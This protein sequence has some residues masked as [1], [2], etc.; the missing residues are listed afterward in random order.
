MTSTSYNMAP[1]KRGELAPGAI[2]RNKPSSP[3]SPSSQQG[4]SSGISQEPSPN[5]GSGASDQ[6]KGSAPPLPD[7]DVPLPDEATPED[8]GWSYTWDEH[9]QTYSFYNRFTGVTQWNNPRVP[10]T[11]TTPYESHI[12]SGAPGTSSP[13]RSLYGGYNP[14]IHGSYDPNADYAIEAR[15]REEEEEEAAAAAAATTSLPGSNGQYTGAAQFNRF[16]GGFQHQSINPEAHNDEN[17]SRRQMN[18]FFDVDAAANSHD[19]RSLKAERRAKTITKKELKAYKEKKR[20][21]R[22]FKRRQWLKD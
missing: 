6:D 13:P 17:K 16:T 14:A 22:E 9:Y 15:R 20:A 12:S 1:A 8:D 18:A 11:T 4:R 5:G 3:Y 7:E 21:K 10:E 2:D 19:G